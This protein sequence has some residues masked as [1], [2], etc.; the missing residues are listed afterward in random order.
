MR[1]SLEPKDKQIDNLQQQLFNLEEVF[2]KQLMLMDKNAQELT[3]LKS[4]VK[5]KHKDLA[6][7]RKETQMK[8]AIILKFAQDVHKIVSTKDDKAYI[9]G[10]MKLNQD[11][12]MSQQ[13]Y[14]SND[15]KRDPEV[16]EELNRQLR[17]MER[18]IAQHK[19]NAI[20][21][22]KRVK[23]DIKKKTKENTSLIMDLNAIKFEDKKQSIA[24]QKKQ[25]E[26]N[27]LEE[28][29]A[30]LK[31][32]EAAARSELNAL[33]NSNGRDYQSGSLG[34]QQRKPVESKQ[35]A[36]EDQDRMRVNE[37]LE[38]IE[39]NNEEILRNK[40]EINGLKIRIMTVLKQ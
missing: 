2:E 27:R 32:A 25:L 22:E 18:S 9:M 30:R 7:K 36:E 34:T 3:K 28:E 10:I 15:K 4:K 12:V 11:Y 38:Q 8:K 33:Q 5:S 26:L 24:L 14:L 31:R 1:A 23:T 17:Y 40:D 39:E 21:N 29:V 16:I 20:K 37:L 13:A 35:T 6:K 19:C